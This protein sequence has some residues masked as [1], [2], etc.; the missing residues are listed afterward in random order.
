M[1]QVDLW[2]VHELKSGPGW[3]YQI[4]IGKITH[5]FQFWFREYADW[6]PSDY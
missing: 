1:N 2:Q 5:F 4:W 6:Q 3:V